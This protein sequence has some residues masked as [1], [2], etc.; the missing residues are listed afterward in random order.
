[1]ESFLI[2]F[3]CSYC[4]IL[5]L[6]TVTKAEEKKTNIQSAI[7]VFEDWLEQNTTAKSSDKTSKSTND[8]KEKPD[9]VPGLGFKDKEAALKTLK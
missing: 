1:M 9:T 7:K 6:F 3:F 4:V 2:R 5:L 8:A